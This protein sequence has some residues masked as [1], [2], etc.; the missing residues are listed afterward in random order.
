MSVKTI[1]GD[2]VQMARGGQFHVITHGCN[3]QCTMGKGIAKTIKQV[4]PEAYKADLA[5]VKGDKKK[6]GTISYTTKGNITIVN[7]YTQ[8]H[9]WSRG[10]EKKDLFEYE[11]F[12]S[13]LKAIMKRFGGSG[14]RFGLPKI[15]AGLA[16]GDWER[17]YG[18]IEEEMGSEDVTVVEFDQ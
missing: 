9:Y 6:L 12:R 18:I 4:W 17:I 14:L 15:G 3:C 16:G 2:L 5:T 11:S 8:F 1:K 7:S 13:C 10:Q